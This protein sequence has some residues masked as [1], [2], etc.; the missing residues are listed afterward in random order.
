MT[1]LSSIKMKRY[2]IM[3]LIFCISC[4]GEK[5]IFDNTA[6]NDS[7][8]QSICSNVDLACSEA[9]DKLHR[10]W[11]G[12]MGAPRIVAASSEKIC[13]AYHAKCNRCS[14]NLT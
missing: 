14:T 10:Q 12:E 8:V 7:E 9:Y 1:N 5:T 11:M 13:E 2:P 6:C 3:L 4:A